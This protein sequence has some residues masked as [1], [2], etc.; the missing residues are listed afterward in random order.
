MPDQSAA[1]IAHPNIA[2]IKY[3]G[4]F[5]N[6][7]R[8]PSNGSISMNLGGLFTKT[9][10]EFG[11][12]LSEDQLI[13]NQQSVSGTPLERVSQF[14][15]V[16][17]SLAGQKVFARVTS[18]N[19]FPVG[20]GI[21]SSAAA[22]AALALAASRAL[23]LQLTESELSRLARRGS[24]S[25]CRSIP[26]GF[27]EWLPGEDDLSSFAV[28]IAAPDYWELVDC[29][30]VVESGPKAVGSTEGHAIAPTSPLQ[31]A[32][33]QDAGRRLAI[34]R[35]AIQ[36]KD[37]NELASITELD[38]NLMHAVMMTSQPP[39]FYWSPESLS[40]MN[41]IPRLRQSGLPVCYTLDA[42]PNV[43]VI[44]LADA[45]PLVQNHLENFPGVDRVWVSSIGGGATLVEEND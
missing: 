18:R 10:V 14:L 1:A 15:D 12:E 40:L 21:A 29:I 16:A 35:H 38:S 30:A 45:A 24:G 7:L 3:W 19:N 2:L 34:C 5:D 25:A 13:I 26:P 22:F 43:H 28:S 33:V 20:A 36:S 6:Q 37:F 31:T 39:L 27:C 23:G 32:R 8:L 9:R 11:A 4:N 42:G 44:C 17:R 41:T